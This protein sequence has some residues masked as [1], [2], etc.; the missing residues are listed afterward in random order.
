VICRFQ[1]IQIKTPS[2]GEGAMFEKYLENIY[3]RKD[4][5]FPTEF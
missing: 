2:C 1:G 5:P 4:N 3:E